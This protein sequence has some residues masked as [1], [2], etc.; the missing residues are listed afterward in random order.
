M[1]SRRPPPIGAHCLILGAGSLG[2]L[3]GTLLPDGTVTLIPRAERKEAR[4]CFRFHPLSGPGRC[5][6]LP[7][8]RPDTDFRDVNL[9]LVT[10]KA[11]H[12]PEAIASLLAR[13][14]GPIPLVLFQNGLGSQ[15]AVLEQCPAHPILAASTTEGANRTAE[16]TL[17]HAGTGDTWVGALNQAGHTVLPDVVTYLQTS[18]L[19]THQEPKIEARLWQK[20]AINAGINPFTAI[21]DC[22]NGDILDHRFYRERIDPLCHE[23]TALMRHEGLSTDTAEALRNRIET[24]ARATA[25]NTSSMRADVRHGRKTEIDFINGFVAKRC[26]ALN[27]TAR[28]NRELTKRVKELET[29]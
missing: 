22:P 15:Q 12:T 27:L 29:A 18:G 17:V 26:E 7:W 2:R 25:R 4:C 8:A 13:L 9:V 20:L 24:V 5:V 28:V 6:A 16:D 1:V 10:T 23:L 21:I 14:P 3:W 11:Q 19:L